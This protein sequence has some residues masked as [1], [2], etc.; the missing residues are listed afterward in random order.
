MKNLPKD[1]RFRY[2]NSQKLFRNDPVTIS[3]TYRLTKA[4]KDAPEGSGKQRGSAFR[5]G[6]HL[7][8][9]DYRRHYDDHRVLLLVC[10]IVTS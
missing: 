3:I 8:G 4:A 9:A 2:H 10:R 7:A 6:Q 5:Q 1:V